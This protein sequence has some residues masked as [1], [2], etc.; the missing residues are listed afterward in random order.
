VLVKHPDS[1]KIFGGYNPIGF[2]GRTYN[3]TKSFIFSFEN[4]EDILNM[5]ISRANGSH[6]IYAINEYGFNIANTLILSNNL[7]IFNNLGKYDYNASYVLSPYFDGYFVPSD[8]NR[9]LR[10]NTCFTIISFIFS[11]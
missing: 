6:A 9:S 1:A 11:L 4:S 2:S 8:R 5:K 3:T 7:V 10:N